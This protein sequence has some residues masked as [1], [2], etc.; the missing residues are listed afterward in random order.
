V[1]EKQATAKA[2]ADF[3]TAAAKCAASGRNDGLGREEETGK[4]N[5]RFSWLNSRF[6]WLCLE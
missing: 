6:S 2:K 1:W 4:G 3:S 5:S